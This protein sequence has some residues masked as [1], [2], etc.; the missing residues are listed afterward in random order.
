MQYSPTADALS[1]AADL[2]ARGEPFVMATVVRAVAPTSAKAGD[3]AVLS[4]DGLLIGW[5]GGSCAEPIVTKEAVAALVDGQCRLVLITPDENPPP[6][7]NGLWVHRMECYS[8]GALEIYLEPFLA[9]PRLLIF[10]NSPVA[11][12]LC[13][14]GRF[15]RYSVTVVD[16]GE[17]PQMGPDI[18]TIRSLQAIPAL[19][20]ARTFAVV[21]SHGVF[22]EE[23][24]EAALKLGL[25]YTGFVTSR[26]RREQVFSSLAAR[27]VAAD[28]LAHV[29]APAGMDLG[30][31]QPEE[32]ALAVMAEVVVT[33][34]RGAAAPETGTRY[35]V[36]AALAVEPASVVAA[37]AT[38]SLVTL[39]ASQA[40]SCCQG[41]D[42]SSAK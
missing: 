6:T 18:E 3:K 5:I 23:S 4:D 8:G 10:G 30:A 16:L 22:D 42:A 13:D 24:L 41:S 11:R 21:A 34:R 28:L 14:L 31:R 37:Q 32:I 20:P 1:V 29:R 2:R 25:P 39:G 17:R 33:R 38:G 12:A 26:K 15:M 40:H 7:G 9:L 35:P 27:G 19:N 36:A